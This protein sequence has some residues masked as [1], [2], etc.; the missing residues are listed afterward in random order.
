MTPAILQEISDT[1][2]RSI[3]R[4][5]LSPASRRRHVVSTPQASGVT[6]PRPV[7]TTRLI[8]SL[9]PQAAAASHGATRRRAIDAFPTDGIFP[10]DEVR[11][12]SLP[13]SQRP[14]ALGR[15]LL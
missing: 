14:S 11:R 6:M 10:P 13:M 2:N 1:S 4:A 8:S 15:Q 3:L 5:P 7:T 12:R 9:R